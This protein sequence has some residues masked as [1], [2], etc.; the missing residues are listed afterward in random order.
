MR[1]DS[2]EG[3]RPPTG[4]TF[5]KD[6]L[7]DQNSGGVINVERRT[8][9]DGGPLEN[10]NTFISGSPVFDSGT[11]NSVAAGFCAIP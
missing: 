6:L 7:F 3:A 4:N 11:I 9:G 10:V 1:P 5:N 2:K 8:G